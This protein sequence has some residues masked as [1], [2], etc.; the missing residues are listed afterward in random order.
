[1]FF[2]I[3]VFLHIFPLLH[4]FVKHFFGVLLYANHFLVACDDG[5][6]FFLE[7]QILM[8]F[9]FV[10]LFSTIFCAICC[11]WRWPNYLE[12]YSSFELNCAFFVPNVLI[13]IFM[14]EKKIK[15]VFNYIFVVAEWIVYS[16]SQNS[17][18]KF[19]TSKNFQH[20]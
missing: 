10:A 18:I 5:N 11:Y 4:F 14:C 8:N 13:S 6:C 7:Q 1:M 19:N 3:F 16:E 9:F 12:L 2:L 15:N 20:I 17:Y